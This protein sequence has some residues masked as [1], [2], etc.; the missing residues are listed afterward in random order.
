VH[1]GVDQLVGQSGLVWFGLF[2]TSVNSH[3][4]FVYLFIYFTFHRSL[5]IEIIEMQHMQY[6]HNNTCPL[7]YS[8]DQNK[9]NQHFQL[10]KYSSV[11]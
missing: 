2:E 7:Q 9:N 10:I 4:S 5:D 3:L 6:N 1:P 8:K 11:K